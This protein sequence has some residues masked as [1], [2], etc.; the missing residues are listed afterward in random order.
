[1]A[2]A[3]IAEKDQFRKHFTKWR[4]RLQLGA[5]SDISVL[6]DGAA[7]IWDMMKSE[8]GNVREGLDGYHALEHVSD[9]GKVLHGE[10]T[11]EYEQWWKETKGELLASGF[12]LLEGRLDRLDTEERTDKEKESLRKLRGY[13]GSHRGRLAYRER[14]AQ[15]RAIGSGQVEGACK[16]LIGARLKLTWAKWK[17]LRLNHMA[18]ICAVRYGSQWKKYWRQAR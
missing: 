13:L 8:F 17:V 10:E 15:G 4:T 5:T 14:L 2:F 3:E 7:W 12:E 18:V 16:N 6:G 1:V 11:A 9:T